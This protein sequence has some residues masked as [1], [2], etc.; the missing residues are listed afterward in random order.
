[1][2][3]AFLAATAVAAS[4]PAVAQTAPAVPAAQAAGESE[5]SAIARERQ[6]LLNRL[7]RLR[8]QTSATEARAKSLGDALV[9]LAGDEAKLRQRQ[10]EVGGR[11]ATLEQRIAGEEEA[12]EALTDRQASIRHELAQKRAELATILMALQRIGRRPPPALFGDTGGPIPTV[13]GAILLNEVLPSL[14]ADARALAETLSEAARLADDERDRWAELR[15]DLS[16]VEE[17]RQRLVELGE[18]LERRR[19]ISLYERDRAAA[20]LTRLAEEEGSVS[21]LLARL[22][23]EGAP[24][25]A[26]PREGFSTRRGSLATPVAGRIVS[27]YGEPTQSGALSEGV[28]IAALPQSTVFSPMPAT[29]LFSSPFRGYGHVLIMDAGDGYHMVLAGLE[30]AAVA[31]GDLVETGAPVGRMGRSSRRSTI[32]SAGAKGSALLQARPALYVEL[33]KDGSAIDS[34]G[35]WREETAVEVGRTGG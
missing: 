9:D 1:M 30:E 35:W 6:Q 2:C 4:M 31:P 20:D 24:K 26:P 3:G 14:D 16:T 29:V 33:R 17:E 18:E 19:A 23:E 13:R 34:H 12:L 25:S 28:T 32:A 10:E 8:E 7:D 21:G 11:V 5:A 22:T 15:R 27:R